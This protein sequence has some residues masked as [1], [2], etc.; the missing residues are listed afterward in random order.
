MAKMHRFS[1]SPW[2]SGGDALT[3]IY[4]VNRSAEK[5]GKSIFGAPVSDVGERD[6]CGER[7][8]VEEYMDYYYKKARA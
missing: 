7:R 1:D 4:V 2:V 3:F 5:R 6:W 8:Y